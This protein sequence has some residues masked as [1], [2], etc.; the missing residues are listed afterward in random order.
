VVKLGFVEHS[1]VGRL[2]ASALVTVVPSSYEGF[3]LP[4][5]EAMGT[6]C[7]VV[8]VRA[9]ALPEVCGD[10]AVLVDTS[11]ESI[12]EGIVRLATCEGLWARMSLLGRNRSEAFSWRRAADEHILA[13]KTA[14]D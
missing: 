9:G 2:M 6:G 8:A 7:P 13:Y 11:P 4:A 14:F 3:G 1:K 5:L 10:A 12:A